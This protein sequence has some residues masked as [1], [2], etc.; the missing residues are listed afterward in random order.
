MFTQPVTQAYDL[1]DATW[2]VIIMLLISFLLGWFFRWLWDHSENPVIIVQEDPRPEKYRKF[3]EES[4]QVVEG[5]GPKIEEL[6]KNNGIMNWHMLATAT[7]ESLK[8]ILQKGGER[9]QMHDPS[10]WPDQAAL[11]IEGKWA[12]LEEYQVLLPGGRLR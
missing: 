3:T 11:A 1:T 2:E 10:S 4:L 9:F 6:L 7:A 12:E 8:A 5:I